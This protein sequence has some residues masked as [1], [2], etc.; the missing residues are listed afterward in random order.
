MRKVY[1]APT[2]ADAHLIAG[3]LRQ[4]GIEARVFNENAQ[5]TA[6]LPELCGRQ[7]PEAFPQ[8]RHASE[9]RVSGDTCA[10]IGY[11][12]VHDSI[13][14]GRSLALDVSFLLEFRDVL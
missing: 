14:S 12:H 13:V 6:D 2:L 1:S 9:G 10:G 8:K 11:G 3:L 4:Q 7:L 5:G